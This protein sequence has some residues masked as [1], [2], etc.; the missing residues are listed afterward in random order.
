MQKAETKDQTPKTEEKS[1]WIKIKPAELE[2]IVVDLAK[3]GNTPA[4]IGLTLRDKHSIPKTKVLAKKVTKILKE[5]NIKYIAEKDIIS[6]KIEKL[7]N[8][9]AKNKYDQSA[10]RSLSKKL[11]LLYALNKQ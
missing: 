7:K 2:K 8:H 1:S 10:K 5:A 6:E 4:K 11:W 9:I 3:E